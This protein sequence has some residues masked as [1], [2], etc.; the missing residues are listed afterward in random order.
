VASALAQAVAV[1]ETDAAGVRRPVN[2]ARTNWTVAALTVAVFSF[3]CV[4]AVS[5]QATML[6]SGYDLGIFDQAVRQYARFH[7]P[8]VALKGYDYNIFADHFHPIIAILAPLYWIWDTPYVLLVTQAV[9]IAAS[10][11]IVFD[12]T[13]RRL[14]RGA[15]LVIAF[16]YGFGWPIQTLVAFDFHE[17]AFAVPLLAGAVNALDKGRDR[18]LVVCAVLLLLTREDMGVL[19]VILGLFR[20]TRAP[21]RVGWIL[22]GSGVAGSLL[23]IAVIIPAVSPSGHFSYWTFSALGP[24]VPSAMHTVLTRPWHVV[25]LFFTPAIKMKTLAYLFLPVALLSL[26]SRYIFLA[27]PLL[28]ERFLNSRSQLWTTEFHYNVLPWLVLVLAMVD[29]ADRL[30][31]W[32]WRPSRYLLLGWLTVVPIALTNWPGPL[33]NLTWQMLDGAAFRLSPTRQANRAALQMIP[34]NVCVWAPDRVVPQLT[35]LDRVTIPGLGGPGPDFVLL[36]MDQKSVAYHRGRP[37]HFLSQMS[38]RGYATVFRHRAVVL[39]RS[40]RY[41]GPSS[42]CSPT[43]P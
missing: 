18:T 38:K 20:L 26:R 5:R 7:A 35:Y 30:G 11:P 37:Q 12:F 32:R 36:D 3:Y 31:V 27:V 10:V 42:R 21:R 9:L 28:A 17:I 23:A 14:P 6:T 19:V 40:P 8:L 39:L 2:T 34:R 16:A 4:Y 41:H 25:D 43:A 15:S 24:D 13:Q 33:P 1:R 29:G 22:V